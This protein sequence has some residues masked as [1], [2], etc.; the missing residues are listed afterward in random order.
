MYAGRIV[1]MQT[2]RGLFYAPRH[3]YTKALLA[4]IPKLGTKEPL[5]A[6]PGQPPDLA[7]LPTGCAFHPRCAH[8]NE[9]CRL[10]APAER[11]SAD[12]STVRCWLAAPA[13]TSIEAAHA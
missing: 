3:P 10:E 7:A 4:S 6:V 12:G 8:A 2:V 11:R 1:E 13:A 9:H 5:Y